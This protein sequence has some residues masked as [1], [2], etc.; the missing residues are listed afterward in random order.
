MKLWTN[1]ARWV[2]PLAILISA[3]AVAAPG[4]Y[5]VLKPAQPTYV[6]PG[7]IEVREFFSYGCPHCYTFHPLLQK[8]LANAPKNVVLVRTPVIFHESWRILAKAYYT[9]EAMGILDKTHAALFEAIHAKGMQFNTPEQ[10]ADFFATRGVDKSD[11]LKT[12]NSFGVAMKLRQGEQMARAYRIMETPTLTV[13]GKY[14]FNP[15]MTGGKPQMIEVLRQ[16]IQKEEDAV[17]NR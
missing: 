1:L 5:K 11:F 13:D 17:A 7:K 2:A 3:T 8:W 12:Y 16:L 6:N 10:L 14:L 4:G 9:E 15:S